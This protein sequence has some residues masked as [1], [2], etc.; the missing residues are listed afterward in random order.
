MPST[1]SI[2]AVSAKSRTSSP[3]PRVRLNQ[4][5]IDQF[6][7]STVPMQHRLRAEMH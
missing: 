3:K 1:L 2:A 4:S 7:L 5:V 6:E